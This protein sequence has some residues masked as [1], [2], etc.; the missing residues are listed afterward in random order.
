MGPR[1]DWEPRWDQFPASGSKSPNEAGLQIMGTE[2]G[3]EEGDMDLRNRLEEELGSDDKEDGDMAFLK[4]LEEELGGE[5]DD[6]D[7]VE[8]DW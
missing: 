1:Y 6:D 3:E 4:M 2:W 8:V 5:D 7:L